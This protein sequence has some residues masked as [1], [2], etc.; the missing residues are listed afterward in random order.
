M[1]AS[2]ETLADDSRVS[3]D[4]RLID[5]DHRAPQGEPCGAC[6][7]PI[8]AADK[9]CPA[10]GT[11][12]A[13][14]AAATAPQ[15]PP[16]KFLRCDACGAEISVDTSARSYTC[17]FCDSNYVVE[18]SPEISNRERPEFVIGF[19]V[20]TEKARELFT[21]WF[22]KSHWFT[23]GD[24]RTTAV[25]DKI[26]GVYLPFWSFAMLARSTWRAEIGEDWYRTETYTTTENGKTV[27]KTRRVQETEYWPLRGRH[28]RY[29]SG[30]LIS[31]SRG[32]K[33]ELAEQ[34]MPFQLPALK[35]FQPSFLAGW[36]TEEYTVSREDALRRCEAE[37]QRRARQDIAAFL[38]GDRHRQL[39]TETSFSQQSS[40]LCLLPV[41]LSA[42]KY[43]NRQYHCLINGQTG[44]LYGQK[45][46]SW[47]RIGGMVL[48]IAGLIGLVVVIVNLLQ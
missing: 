39:Q 27:T 17:P 25:A 41:Y 13:P 44:R 32:L 18:F 40:D 47:K 35:R 42:Y 14:P 23:P 16:G 43:R 34:I 38:P 31:A 37:F 36:M 10:C 9:F 24:L 20:T 11:P 46:L 4:E 1:S 45:P 21:T 8:E 3:P 5:V 12:H 22:Q 29:Y 15:E 7:C 28:E 30:Y 2:P 33:Q 48:A 26:R 6:G 19:A